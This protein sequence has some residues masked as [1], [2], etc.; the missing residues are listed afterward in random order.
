MTAV[1]AKQSGHTE[2]EETGFGEL[3]NNAAALSVVVSR[4]CRSRATSSSW[5]GYCHFEF[6]M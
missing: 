2:P 5:S 3:G 4:F 6:R 1:T